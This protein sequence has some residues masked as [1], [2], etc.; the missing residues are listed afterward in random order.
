MVGSETLRAPGRRRRTRLVARVGLRAAPVAPARPVGV[1]C[2]ARGSAPVRRRDGPSRCERTGEERATARDA[3]SSRSCW[4]P[5]CV[6]RRR[7]SSSR[8]RSS[9][10]RSRSPST[11]SSTSPSFV[12]L[13]NFGELADD[14]VF[15]IS[16]RNSLALRRLRGAA[17]PGRA[18]WGWR[19]CCTRASAA[20]APTARPRYLPTVVPDVAYAL[21]WLWLLNPLYGPINVLLGAS[22]DST[23]P[24]LADRPCR[25]AGG[26]RAHERLPDRGGL[27]R[28]ARH[29]PGPAAGAVRAGLARGA[30][31]AS[32]SSGASPCR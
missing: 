21:L 15:G 5:T 30:R 13:D 18:R 11:T 28:R 1:S 6:G 32:T 14:A 24:R 31:A 20:S 2:A 16:V 4:R 19:C 27:R 29:A 25:R 22:S 10:S 17:A 23:E 8:R 3:R 9:R 7:C 26:D 12:G